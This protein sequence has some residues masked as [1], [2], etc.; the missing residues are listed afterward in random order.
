MDAVMVSTYLQCPISD[1]RTY[2]RPAARAPVADCFRD[3]LEK[4]LQKR[5]RLVKSFYFSF[6]TNLTPSLNT[7]RS[8]RAMIEFWSGVQICCACGGR[9]GIVRGGRQ[10]ALLCQID[11]D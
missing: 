6:L 1:R 5:D 9:T 8:K 4:E 2:L 3:V 11:L 10:G 7:S